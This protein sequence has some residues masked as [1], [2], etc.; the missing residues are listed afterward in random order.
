[1]RRVGE[2]APGKEAGIG[3]G[4]PGIEVGKVGIKSMKRRQ[5]KIS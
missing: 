5:T 2:G 3:E 4:A 1:M